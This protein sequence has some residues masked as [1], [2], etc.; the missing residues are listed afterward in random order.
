MTMKALTRI[1]ALLLLVVVLVTFSFAF[2]VERIAPATIGVKQNQLRGG[3]VERDFGL[4]YH[5]GIAGV[6]KWYRLDGRVHFVN[7][8]SEQLSTR[9]S[10]SN[11]DYAGSLDI[12]TSDN[13]TA[14]LDVTVAYRI[15]PGRAWQVV[16][17][18]FQLAYRDRVQR[19]ISGLLQEEL[20]KLSPE[21]FVSSEVRIRRVEETMPRVR[22]ELEKFHMEPIT[23][24]IRAVRFPQEY[25]QK[26]QLKQL[27]RQKALLAEARQ[28]QELQSQQTE[29]Y[30]K[31]TEALEKRKRGEWDVQL[32]E[33]RS[34]N[35]VEIAQIAA[36]ARIYD[37]TT[38]AEAEATAVTAIAEGDLEIAKAEALR[39][40]LRNTALSSTGGRI[41]LARQAAESL[42]F[43]SVTLNS[44]DPSVPTILDLTELVKLLIGN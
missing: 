14:S 21:D 17:D 32:Q 6:H 12:R 40:Q 37:Q 27:T 7:F 20:S 19:V 23:I 38:R 18:G 44:N 1:G 29:A 31:E 42:N 24:L 8:S 35:Q 22:A 15:L 5:L 3:I 9:E 41:L 36:D 2:L 33:K 11:V 26:L 39:N 28:K 43:E 13:N 34:T 16:R 25:E 30:E 10:A 4:G